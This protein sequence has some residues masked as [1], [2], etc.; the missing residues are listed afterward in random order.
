M[1]RHLKKCLLPRTAEIGI[2]LRRVSYG[3]LTKG[4]EGHLLIFETFSIASRA[5]SLNYE[6][7]FEVRY[8]L[9]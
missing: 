5:A 9:N 8:R 1:R 3:C 6:R 7:N 2:T 4:R